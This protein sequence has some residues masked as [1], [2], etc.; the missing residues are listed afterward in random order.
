MHQ[1]LS[2]TAEKNQC[3]SLEEYGLAWRKAAGVH[4]SD[5]EGFSRK[6][7]SIGVLI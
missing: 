1:S 2:M 3:V 7:G 4:E 6:W 5:Q